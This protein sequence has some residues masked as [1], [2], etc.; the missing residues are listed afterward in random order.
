MK[1]HGNT[2]HGM[3]GTRTYRI[4]CGIKRRCDNPRTD[5]YPRYGGR[6]ISY[7]PR[8]K[9][10]PEF[11]AD[12]GKAP[13]GLQIDRIDG[14]ADYSKDNC[15]WV[16]PREN[17]TNRKTNVFLNYNGE[18]ITVTELARRLG[19]KPITLETRLWRLGWSQDKAVSTPVQKWKRKVAVLAVAVAAC[20]PIEQRPTEVRTQV[21]EVRVPIP[22]PCFTEAERPILPP[23]TPI[24]IDHAT[25]DQL[26]AALAADDANEARY[27]R[28]VDALFLL[29]T[30]STGGTK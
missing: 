8:W 1:T 4:W 21:V 12:M 24:D 30:K 14:D 9:Q 18:R 26:A 19:M 17:A 28:E 6:G 22:T 16:T 25:T 29:C 23:P 20:A 10:F 13:E 2:K 11:F 7:D 15:R 5:S 3:D 27:V